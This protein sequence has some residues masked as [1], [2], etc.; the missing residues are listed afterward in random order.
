MDDY[1]VIAFAVLLMF[2]IFPFLGDYYVLN[3]N[4]FWIT[5]GPDA[6][7]LIVYAKTNPE[8]H[9]RGIT[10]FII[11]KVNPADSRSPLPCYF[12]SGPEVYG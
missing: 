11:E 4:K 2:H 9:Q 3:G 6:D 10:A 5:N 1:N 12:Q 7:V 8:A